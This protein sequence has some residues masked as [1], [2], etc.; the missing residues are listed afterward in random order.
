[1]W[2]HWDILS[3]H[4]PVTSS[5]S[6]GPSLLPHPHHS[7]VDLPSWPFGT[8][9]IGPSL[10][11]PLAFLHEPRLP[12]LLTIAHPGLLRGLLCFHLLSVTGVL[13][14]SVLVPSALLT[15][16]A[17]LHQRFFSCFNY[18]IYVDVSQIVG[19]CT[20]MPA[21]HLRRGTP[22]IPQTRHVPHQAEY[23]FPLTN[24]PF[25]LYLPGQVIH[26]K[27]PCWIFLWSSF[28]NMGQTQT[29]AVAS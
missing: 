27:C 1:M 20:E 16:Y 18:Y 12:R 21:S 26:Q 7:L 14:S 15:Q 25:L 19:F 13:S 11:A 8:W 3:C 29:I 22:K 4:L 6:Q 5:F 17:L 23:I 24:L 10:S 9:T 28:T 2:H